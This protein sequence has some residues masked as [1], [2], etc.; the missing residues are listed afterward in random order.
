MET[1]SDL[2]VS[3]DHDLKLICEKVRSTVF[4]KT[5]AVESYAVGDKCIPSITFKMFHG[6]RNYIICSN[7]LEIIQVL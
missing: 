2:S 4:Y 3:P 6:V 1:R 7:T 5:N